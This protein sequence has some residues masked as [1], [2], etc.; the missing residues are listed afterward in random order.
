M[1]SD[2]GPQANRPLISGVS[3]LLLYSGGHL[4]NGNSAGVAYAS[5]RSGF[6][7]Y[8]QQNVYPARDHNGLFL[9]DPVD[10]RRAWQLLDPYDDRGKGPCL[11]AD[12]PAE[13]VSLYGGRHA[14]NLGP[15]G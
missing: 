9:P 10:P 5:R 13:L 1:A 2:K 8:L 7:G 15:V 3:N 4:R 12:Q 6:V 11:S 14:D